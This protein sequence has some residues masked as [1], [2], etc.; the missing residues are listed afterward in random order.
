MDLVKFDDNS[1]CSEFIAFIGV[2]RF[3]P[4]E[5]NCLSRKQFEIC[6]DRFPLSIGRNQGRKLCRKIKLLFFTLLFV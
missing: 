6:D 2:I 1:L 4:W 3:A 5:N